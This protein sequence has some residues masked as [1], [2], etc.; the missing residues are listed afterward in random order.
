M[1]LIFMPPLQVVKGV[2]YA[3]P[4][5]MH[6]GPYAVGGERPVAVAVHRQKVAGPNGCADSSDQ[7]EEW[8]ANGECDNNPVFMVGTRLNPGAC[9]YSCGKCDML[10]GGMEQLH[11]GRKGGKAV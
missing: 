3:M 5:W 2:K 6:V 10:T 1:P 7:C 11:M 8:A 9:L 4:R